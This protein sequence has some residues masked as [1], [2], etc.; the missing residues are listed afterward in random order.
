MHECMNCQ[1][2]IFAE[3]CP[4]G[5]ICKYKLSTTF[6]ACSRTYHNWPQTERLAMPSSV[7]DGTFSFPPH[8]LGRQL[9]DLAMDESVKEEPQ[10]CGAEESGSEAE[11]N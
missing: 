4:S 1:S 7:E 3:C 6:T 8:M 5:H 11:L 2:S 10:D 9:L